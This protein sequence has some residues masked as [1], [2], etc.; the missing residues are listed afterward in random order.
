[1]SFRTILRRS[2]PICLFLT[3]GVAGAAPP[4]WERHAPA[5]EPRTEVAAAV[6]RG[7]IVVAGGFTEGGG[8]S[9][10]V[11]A[12]AVAA[13]R[14]RRLPDL[15]VAVDHAA[16]ASA[17]GNVYVVGGYGGDRS[18]LRTAFVLGADEEWRRLAQMPDGRAAAA[19]AIAGGKLYV[20]GGVDGRRTLARVAFALD[21]RTG[22]WSR[23]PGPAPREHL[24]AAAVGTRVYALAGRS[25]GIDTNT[26][27]FEAYDARTRRWTR[28]APVPQARGGTGA[29]FANGRIVSV[30]G[31]R[32][33]G[34]IRSVYAYEP[35]TRRWH[36]LADLPTPR[37]GLGVVAYRGRVYAVLGGPVPGLTVSGAVESLAVG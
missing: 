23:I 21:L 20:V 27:R 4:P 10:R 31:E 25:A 13:N 24:A 28:L 14:W 11:D 16:A 37:H 6:A 18:P 12:Y 9:P 22:R 8:S 29:A 19:A 1:M 30:G 5:P 33:Q 3:V 17:N 15:P 34:T 2:L 35:K 7:E 32:P 36:R 26:N